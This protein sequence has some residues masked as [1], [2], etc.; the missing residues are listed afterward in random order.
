MWAAGRWGQ[1]VSLPSLQIGP[2][3]RS[4]LEAISADLSF[5][6]KFLAVH[7]D[8]IVGLEVL[9]QKPFIIDYSA[10]LIRFGVIPALPFT[11]PLRLHRSLAVLDAE[12]DHVP[13]HL[14]FDTGASSLVLFTPVNPRG[15]SMNVVAVLRPEAIGKFEFK[16]LLAPCRDCRRRCRKPRR[17]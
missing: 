17:D 14:L 11:V 16:N 13:L 15:S 1:E 6:Q 12:I 9:G 8:A 5:F 4:N 7:I 10:R 2:V 3:H